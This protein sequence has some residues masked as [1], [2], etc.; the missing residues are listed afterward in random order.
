MPTAPRPAPGAASAP[1]APPRSRSSAIDITRVEDLAQ[2]AGLGHRVHSLRFHGA[3][4]RR[5][6]CWTFGRDARQFWCRPPP[7]RADEQRLHPR[8]RDPRQPR[9]RALRD[10]MG[11]PSG[12]RAPLRPAAS[13]SAR[14]CERICIALNDGLEDGPRQRLRPYLARTIGTADDGLDEA[15]SWMAMDWLIRVY[16]PAWLIAGRSAAIRP[17]ELARAGAGARRRRRCATALAALDRA[18]REARGARAAERS[19]PRGR[20]RARPPARR[21]GHAPARPRGRPR[22]WR[23]ATSPATGRAPRP[24]PPPPTPPPWSPREALSQA[25][26]CRRAR[27]RQGCGPARWLRPSLELRALGAGAA[28]ADAADRAV[29]LPVAPRPRRSSQHLYDVGLI[30]HAALT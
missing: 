24:A 30:L 23:S 26:A 2:L 21:P 27:G 29:E 18:R 1:P 16:T 11:Q 19:A 4:D 28:G 5:R 14:C 3:P 9:G 22:G 17:L 25:G 15:R 6:S 7:R 12:R 13:A 20:R 8:L 10:G